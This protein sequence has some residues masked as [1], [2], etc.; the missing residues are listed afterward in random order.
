[1]KSTS[2]WTLNRWVVLGLVG[3]Y[4][5]LFL[6]IRYDHNHVLRHHAIAWTPIL[7]SAAM[8][9]AGLAALATWE[10]GGRAVLRWLFALGLAVGVLGWWLHN[11]NHPINGLGTMLSVWG[12][13]HPDPTSRPPVLAPLAFAGLGLL[14]MIA[15]ADRFQSDAVRDGGIGRAEPSRGEPAGTGEGKRP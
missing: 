12:G 6:E 13:A 1:M 14:G 2:P 4:G 9:A 5:M 3:A 11:G 7:Y 10:R 8:V 15:C